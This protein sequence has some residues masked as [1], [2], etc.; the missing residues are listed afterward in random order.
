MAEDTWR[1]LDRRDRSRPETP[2]C[3][4]CGAPPEHMGV[5]NRTAHLVYLKCDRCGFVWTL[6]IP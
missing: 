5:T 4:S 3:R 2:P 1:G 6:D